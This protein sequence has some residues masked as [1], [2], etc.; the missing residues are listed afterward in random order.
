MS[1]S[2]TAGHSN[3]QGMPEDGGD[4]AQHE[5]DLKAMNEEVCSLHMNCAGSL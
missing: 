5:A 1:A 3:G 4:M 2:G